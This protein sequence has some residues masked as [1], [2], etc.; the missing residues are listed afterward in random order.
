MISVGCEAL[1]QTGHQRRRWRRWASNS[2]AA[3]C[4]HDTWRDRNGERVKCTLHASLDKLKL[5]SL[6][7][8]LTTLFK[9]IFFTDYHQYY[10][11]WTLKVNG[12]NLLIS[13]SS[14]SPIWSFKNCWLMY[15]SGS[16][17]HHSWLIFDIHKHFTLFEVIKLN[18]WNVILTIF[19]IVRSIQWK[20]KLFWYNA[21]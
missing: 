18:V 8:W 17:L 2:G 20:Y 7:K 19:L 11:F 21:K 14:F 1:Q 5:L 3:R 16:N 15:L 9:R 12:L 4:L 13:F 10:T 6:F